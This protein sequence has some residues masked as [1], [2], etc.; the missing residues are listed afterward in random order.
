MLLPAPWAE[1]RRKLSTMQRGH[2]NSLLAHWLCF[3]AHFLTVLPGA[4]FTLPGAALP[5]RGWQPL[6]WPKA[7]LKETGRDS[8][9]DNT[10]PVIRK[11]K[12]GEWV[13]LLGWFCTGT[14]LHCIHFFYEM[15]SFECILVLGAQKPGCTDAEAAKPTPKMMNTIQYI[16]NLLYFICF[17]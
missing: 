1:A 9:N 5:Q 17:I 12:Y 16:A 8:D 11:Q 3:R 10:T 14:S 7:F 15:E 13:H 2:S 4:C 6:F